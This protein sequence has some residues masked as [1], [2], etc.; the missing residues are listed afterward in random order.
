MASSKMLYKKK[1]KAKYKN[2]KKSFLQKNK[3]KID[4]IENKYKDINVTTTDVKILGEQAVLCTNLSTGTSNS[5][6]IGK[7]V[8][9][10][11]IQWKSLL[12][13][14]NTAYLRNYIVRQVLVY[15]KDPCGS[16]QPAL[17][18]IT[19]STSP[20]VTI[21]GGQNDIL[22]FPNIDNKDRFIL[23]SDKTYDCSKV[24]NSQAEDAKMYT[25][26]KYKKL[27]VPTEYAVSASSGSYDDHRVGALILYTIVT[28]DL[29]GGDPLRQ[30]TVTTNIRL[31]YIDL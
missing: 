29:V 10:K 17:I 5:Q 24:D 27:N 14:G 12:I 13:P 6:R 8:T 1:Y 31:K 25:W 21:G 26:S 19:G 22:A 28:N 15:D 30:P 11:S 2:K 23:I 16:T 20:L 4:A 9:L 7:N 3:P 18:G